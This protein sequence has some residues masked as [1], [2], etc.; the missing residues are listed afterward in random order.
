[1]NAIS[2]ALVGPSNLGNGFTPAHTGDVLTAYGIGLSVLTPVVATGQFPSGLASTVS[3]VSVSIGGVLLAPSDLLY[4]G[5]APA[6]IIDQL[7]FRI[8]TGVPVGNR[9]I[10]MTVAGVSSPPNAFVAI[11]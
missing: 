11:Q 3:P 7:N 8:P 10:R 2:G 1:M 5:A 9:P 4:A 6:E